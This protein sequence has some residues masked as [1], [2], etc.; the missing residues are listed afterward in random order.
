[1]SPLC[2]VNSISGR[3]LPFTSATCPRFSVNNS[4]ASRIFFV[5]V[6]TSAFFVLAKLQIL[7]ILKRI[8]W[9]RTKKAGENFFMIMF[10]NS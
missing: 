2:A 5:Y 4:D 10:V 6:A 1:M 3:G 8:A 7:I 9:V